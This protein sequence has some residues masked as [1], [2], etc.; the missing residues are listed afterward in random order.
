MALVKNNQL[1]KEVFEILRKRNKKIRLS[2][3]RFIIDRYF[4]YAIPAMINGY[5]LG[6][7]KQLSFTIE[8]IL[9]LN[10]PKRYRRMFS[11][12]SKIFGYTFL[13]VCNHHEIKNAG[14]NFKPNKKILDRIAEFVETDAIYTL[15]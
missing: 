4:F 5:C 2:D 13:P 12:S 14:Y 1:N 8:S 7:S 15:I 6:G 10:I 9:Y 3:I 11:Y